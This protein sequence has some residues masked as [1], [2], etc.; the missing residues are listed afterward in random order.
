[1]KNEPIQRITLL[2][3]GISTSTVYCICKCNA[4]YKRKVWNKEKTRILGYNYKC[5]ECGR[6][7]TE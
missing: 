2:K 3:N 1:M 6:I 4:W 7:E 5:A